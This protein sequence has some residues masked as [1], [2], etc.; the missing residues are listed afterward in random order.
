MLS[1]VW[2]NSESWRVGGSS[3]VG[4]GETGQTQQVN[5]DLSRETRLDCSVAC[6][7]NE[8][9]VFLFFKFPVFKFKKTTTNVAT[10]GNSCP[11]VSVVTKF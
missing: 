6:A 9:A 5:V 11:S 1:S 8:R 10:Y 4:G 7:F 3:N 2:S